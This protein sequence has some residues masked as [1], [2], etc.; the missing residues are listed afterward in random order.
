[1]RASA[2]SW[3]TRLRLRR[4]RALLWGKV[5]EAKLRD[6]DR[7]LKAFDPNQPR[8]PAGNS[9]GGQWTD[10]GDGGATSDVRVAQARRGDR[11]RGSD[12]EATPAQLARRDIAEAQSR[13]ARR[14]V[15]EIDPS[16]RPQASLTKPNSIE[17]EIA[18]AQAER[19]EA[20]IRLHE[21]AQEEPRAPMD[22]FRRQHGL[23]LLGDPIWSREQN[24]VSTCQ[25]EGIPHIGVNS[26][27]LTY[28]SRDNSRAE[29]LRDALIQD[30][31]NRMD[32][33]NIGH[34]PNNAVFH[35]ETTCL[36]R[37]ARANGGTLFSKTIEVTVDCEIC[38]SCIRIL[39]IIGLELGNPTVTF[40]SPS[41]RV[42]TMRDGSWVK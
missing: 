3:Q 35:A 15:N 10:G 26:Q 37:A 42:R 1:V 41:G 22:A 20:E 7:A 16:W 23:D 29:Q 6:L 28:S 39:P 30:F 40:A 38:P 36:L 5:A 18:R 9:D 34:F 12:A 24:S 11:G 17:G 27:A 14:R 31:P 19:Q 32:T 4:L 33:H 21:L 8:V 25:V 13:A 2:A